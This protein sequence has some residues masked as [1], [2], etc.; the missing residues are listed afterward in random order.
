MPV[1]VL[2]GG[3]DGIS[4][5][6]Q[7]FLYI[8]P[9]VDIFF[10]SSFLVSAID[11]GSGYG[12][13]S[14]AAGDLVGRQPR[15][16]HSF[17][18]SDTFH[19][20]SSAARLLGDILSTQ[21]SP[22]DSKNDGFRPAAAAADL[23]MKSNAPSPF[24]PPR[25]SGKRP[26]TAPHSGVS[27]APNYHL[28]TSLVVRSG[29]SNSNAG[30]YD[31]H[32]DGSSPPLRRHEYPPDSKRTPLDVWDSSEALNW[33][34]GGGGAAAAD[35][36]DII[37]T[38]TVK[39][40]GFHPYAIAQSPHPESAPLPQSHSHS[41]SVTT[42]A[43]SIAS[44]AVSSS[45]R[46]RGGGGGGVERHPYADPSHSHMPTEIIRHRDAGLVLSA[47]DEEEGYDERRRRVVELPPSYG[48]IS[49]GNQNYWRGRRRGGSG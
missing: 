44:S 23:P 49:V 46:R 18:D 41:L 33:R 39:P 42:A 32:G 14:T 26:S 3:E 15:R 11:E 25:S 35:I 30:D 22:M 1:L 6:F 21:E 12:N 29:R 24:S 20:G 5:E 9:P 48:E 10:P 40:V 37:P 2:V 19:D 47:S 17:E 34:P 7:Y 13:G 28:P 16:H 8:L 38:A 36:V 27:T 43:I 45:G 31:G 4:R